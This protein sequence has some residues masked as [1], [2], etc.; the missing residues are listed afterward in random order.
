VDDHPVQ[1]DLRIALPHGFSTTMGQQGSPVATFHA[2]HAEDAQYEI[3]F[4][5]DR[6][7]VFQE[8][9]SEAEERI[10]L[11]FEE[12]LRQM[13]DEQE[14]L[15]EDNPDATLASE[16]LKEEDLKWLV[17]FQV[18]GQDFP[19]I[20]DLEKERL[21]EDSKKSTTVRFQVRRAAEVLLGKEFDTWLRPRRRGKP[22][23][24][25]QAGN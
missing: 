22:P 20:A 8:S 7:A 14:R 6:W 25:K 1:M 9:R 10:R 4:R 3:E 2:R 23:K 15:L 12:C 16:E 13:L 21:K 18:L 5:V 11:Q 24:R 19:K 17:Q